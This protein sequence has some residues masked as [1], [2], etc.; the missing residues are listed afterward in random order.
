VLTLSSTFFFFGTAGVWVS[1]MGGGFHI[2]M[3]VEH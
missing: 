3:N 2:H 1:K